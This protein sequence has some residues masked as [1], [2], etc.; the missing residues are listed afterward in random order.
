MKSL[1]QKVG[2]L[3]TRQKKTLSVAESCTGGLISNRITN[4]SGSSKYFKAA[5]VAYSNEVKIQQLKIP[6]RII[7][8]NGAVS[9]EVAILM[10]RNIRKLTKT[11]IG[12]GITGVAGPTGATKTKPVGLVY[13]ALATKDNQ[14]FKKFNFK[15][16]RLAIKRKSA[17]SSLKLLKDYLTKTK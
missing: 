1:E 17:S 15:G 14:R 2:Q 8:Q 13:V 9:K 5:I 10:A 16:G 3:L 11:D 6:S 4:I 7:K 12:L